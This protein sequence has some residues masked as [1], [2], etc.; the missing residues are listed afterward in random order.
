MAKTPQEDSLGFTSKGH[1][2]RGCPQTSDPLCSGS[3]LL[4][5]ATQRKPPLRLRFN[6]RPY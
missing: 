5:V 6:P 2:A 3:A 1:H 4:C